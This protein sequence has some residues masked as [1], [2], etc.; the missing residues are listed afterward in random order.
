MR[1]AVV[2]VLSVSNSS[3]MIGVEVSRCAS[4]VNGGVEHPP[5]PHSFV[6]GDLVVVAGQ[7]GD[8]GRFELFLVA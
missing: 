6:E 3:S 1:L 8:E 4:A 2:P 7:R 5:G